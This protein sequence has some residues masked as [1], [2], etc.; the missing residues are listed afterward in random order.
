MKIELLYSNRPE[1]SLSDPFPA[2]NGF[3]FRLLKGDVCD[4]YLDPD[5]WFGPQKPA[6]TLRFWSSIPL[7]Y[8]AYRFGKRA[9]YIGFKA[10]GVDSEQYKGWLSASDVYPGS[11]ALC[12]T[13]RPFA[14]L[15]P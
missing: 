14:T 5:G 1:Q 2:S 10:Y 4:P 11:Q 9:G 7:P 6:F 15:S 8:F 3:L 12:L 13:C